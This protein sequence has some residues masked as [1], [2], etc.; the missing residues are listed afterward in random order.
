MLNENIFTRLRDARPN[1]STLWLRRQASRLTNLTPARMLSDS[2]TKVNRIEKSG[3]YLFIYDPKTKKKLPYYDTF[4]LVFI[5]D[6]I[7]NGFLG[8]NF[9]YLPPTLRSLFLQAVE[10]GQNPTYNS[11]KKNK[12]LR[13]TIKKYLNKNVKSSFIKIEKEDR[14]MSIY[15]PVEQFTKASKSQVWKDSR[16]MI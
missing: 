4:P 13:P 12:Y 2:T 9:H 14:E 3:M 16:S 11:L 5:I 6:I 8:V 10:R 1:Q 7:P 15:L